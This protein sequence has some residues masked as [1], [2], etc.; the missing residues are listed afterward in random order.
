MTHRLVNG[1]VET[2]DLGKDMLTTKQQQ[3]F[4]ENGYLVV[5]GVLPKTLIEEMASEAQIL[6]DKEPES[7]VWKEGVLFGRSTFQKILDVSTLI[8]VA[9]TL[10]DRDI[11]LLAFELRVVRAGQESVF[12]HRDISFICNKT[13]AVNTAIYLQD[14]TEEVGGLRVVPGS[15]R[16]EHAPENPYAD[17]LPGQVYLSAP[18]GSAVFHSSDIWHSASPNRSKIDCQMLFPHFGRYWLKQFDSFVAQ[19]LPDSLLHTQEPMKRQLLGLELRS[20]VQ[21]FFF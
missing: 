6:T 5:E 12:W 16:W 20:E 2:E 14:T 9:Q 18:A 15:H 21:P 19:P 3:F 4:A 7:C 17:C 11:Q 10:I 1:E 8:E 13:L